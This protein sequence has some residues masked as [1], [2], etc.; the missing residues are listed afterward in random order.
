M[1]TNSKSNE[2][3]TRP[4]KKPNL[5]VIREGLLCKRIAERFTDYEDVMD[6]PKLTMK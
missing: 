5:A 2:G 3:K 4:K 1:D 6:G